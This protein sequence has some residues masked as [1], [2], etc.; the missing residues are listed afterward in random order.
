MLGRLFGNKA[1]S[2]PNPEPGPQLA[3]LALKSGKGLNP[4]AICAAWSKLFPKQA[5]LADK[6]ATKKDGQAVAEFGADGRSLMLAAMPMPIPKGDVDSACQLSWMWPQAAEEMKAQRAHAI[7]LTAPGGDPVGDAMAVSRL[8][9]A[10]ASAGDPAG[11]YWGNGSMMHKPAM[12]IDAV[13]SF[14]ADGPPPVMLWV[15]VLMSADGPQ[16]PF[17]I[18]TRGMNPFGHKELEI[19]DAQPRG[20]ARTGVRP[21]LLPAHQRAGA[22]AQPYVRADDGREDAGRAHHVQVPQGRAGDP[23]AHQVSAVRRSGPS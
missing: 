23:A 6:G 15:G 14:D 19:I 8:L 20:T 12:F 7:V 13:S 17:T 5:P 21:H 9:A 10:A 2:A 3:M 11:I 16:G 18:T 22:Q 1:A 4:P